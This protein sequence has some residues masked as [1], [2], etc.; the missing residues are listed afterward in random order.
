MVEGV[1]GRKGRAVAAASIVFALGWFG[2]S[3]ADTSAAPAAGAPAA[4]PAAAPVPEIAPGILQGYLPVE[5]IPD[6]AAI[7]PP[8]PAIGSAAYALDA[9]A[10][11]AALALRDTPRWKLAALDANLR[12]PAAADTFSCAI[13]APVNETVTPRLYVM[14][15]RMLADSGRATGP[16][17]KK[18]LHA[19]PF[20]M[21]AAPT[22]APD[23]DEALRKDGSYPS[24]HTSIGWAWALVLAELVPD[25][26]DAIIERGLSFGESRVV[27]NVHWESDIVGG[28][29]I[30]SAVVAK[31]HTDPQFLADAAAA[32]EEIAAARAKGLA[33]NRDCNFEHD[34]L[35]Q[36][37][38]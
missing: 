31:L 8:P 27:C 1:K 37:A 16:A 14:L 6:S 38:P 34:A 11:R 28:R 9:E 25:R 4:A 12:F 21:D 17:K 35:G 5:A 13:S 29:T 10:A 3:Y 22:C 19:R 20:M 26:A 7:L 15:R 18:Y 23:Q 30:G 24:G 32:K 2:P 36:S 33:P